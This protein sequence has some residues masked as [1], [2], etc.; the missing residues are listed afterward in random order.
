MRT[1]NQSLFELY[2]QGTIS[3]DDAKRH[4]S[5]EADFD[6]LMERHGGGSR[7]GGG[8]AYGSGRRQR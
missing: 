8:Y 7:A 6:R 5:D 3:F 4:S 2:K 1:M